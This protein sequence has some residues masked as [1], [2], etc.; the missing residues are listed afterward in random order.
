MTRV[1]LHENRLINR[2][3]K[4]SEGVNPK[5]ALIREGKFARKCNAKW[6]KTHIVSVTIR[7]RR[8][9]EIKRKPTHEIMNEYLEGK[10]R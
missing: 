2:I 10:V 9:V 1:Q 4:K 3:D 6:S 7:R 8:K 5:L